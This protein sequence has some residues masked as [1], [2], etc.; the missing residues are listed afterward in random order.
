MLT[1][2]RPGRASS[3]SRSFRRHTA[4][5][6]RRLARQEW[7]AGE[8]ISQA[9]AALIKPEQL[10]RKLLSAHAVWELI[11]TRRSY[12]AWRGARKKHTDAEARPDADR[13]ELNDLSIIEGTNPLR[14]RNVTS[15]GLCFAQIL[16]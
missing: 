7:G 1:L 8:V 3:G 12:A 4:Q 15:T 13:Q 2:R 11:L 16:Q 6:L 10:N 14:T 5:V 9:F